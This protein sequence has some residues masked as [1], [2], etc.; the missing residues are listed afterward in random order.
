MCLFFPEGSFTCV[1]DWKGK[2]R[3]IQTQNIHVPP[4]TAYTIGFSAPVY[5]TSHVHSHPW[6]E[7][8]NKTNVLQTFSRTGALPSNSLYHVEETIGDVEEQ[9]EPMK[10]EMTAPAVSEV[11]TTF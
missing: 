7:G 1:G 5:N 10:D 3:I 2:P 11:A 8:Y 6:K 4:G 9:T